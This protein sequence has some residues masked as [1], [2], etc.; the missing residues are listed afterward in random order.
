MGDRIAELLGIWTGI[1][2]VTY[3]VGL[4]LA[5]ALF[6]LF[7]LFNYSCPFAFWKCFLGLG[8]S[9]LIFQIIKGYVRS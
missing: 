3:I 4:I 6:F 8:T 9:I 2:I 1:I 7:W 5:L